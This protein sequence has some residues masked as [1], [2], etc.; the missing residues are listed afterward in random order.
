MPSGAEATVH[1]ARRWWSQNASTRKVLVKLDFENAFNT[2]SRQQ[3]LDS[4]RDAFPALTRWVSWCYGG[5][6]HLQFGQS[7]VQSS[8]GVQQGDPLGPLLFAAALQPLAVELRNSNLDMATFY[9]DDGI[10]AGDLAAVSGALRHV[11]Q[12]S[13]AMGL[14]LNLGKCDIVA[15]GSVSAAELVPHFPDALLRTPDGANRLLRNFELLGA[16]IGE[17][18]FVESHTATRVASANKLLDAIA[19]IEDCQVA[20]R[21]LRACAGHTRITHSIRCTPPSS[22]RT[23]LVNFDLAVR[24]CFSSFSGIHLDTVQW[25]QAGRSLAQAGLGLRSA[26]RDATA[27]YLAS[28]GSTASQAAALYGGYLDAAVATHPP[29]QDA[30]ASFNS[31]LPTGL[32][33]DSVLA[34]RQRSLT[35]LTDLASWEHHL[36]SASV[37]FQATLRSEAEPG[38]RAF[39]MAFPAGRT[40]MEPAAFTAELRHRLGVADAREEAWCPKCDGV[41][42]GFSYHAATCC[43]G[44]ERTLR[45][46][47]VRDLLF[48]WASRAGLQPEKEKAELLIPLRPDDHRLTGRRPADLFVPSYLGSPTAFD[49]AF[50]SPQRSETLGTA[51]RHALAAATAYCGTKRAHLQT[52]DLCGSQGIR[53]APLVAETTAAWEPSAAAFLKRMARAVAA[54]EGADAAQLEGQ[55]LQELCVTAR[56]FRARAVLHR[57][58]E[59]AALT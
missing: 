40:R 5:P 53:F 15:C 42:D 51:S 39:L 52:E 2:I 16:A 20:L 11:Q 27:A 25:E 50:T 30:L 24:S 28:V 47:A 37:T 54:R 32:D 46:T 57:R 35:H 3:V 26:T 1:A 12:R 8:G 31:M 14:R 48:H 4:V 41:L 36:A 38:A 56:A 10:L 19:D 44:G 55:L 7:V 29:V 17:P 18:A 13:A 58:A 34:K 49:L 21:L 6:S 59:L 33:D 22:H 45:H 23:A 9:L 43:A